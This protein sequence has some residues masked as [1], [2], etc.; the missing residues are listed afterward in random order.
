MTKDNLSDELFWALSLS[1]LQMESLGKCEHQSLLGF[2]RTEEKI[3]NYFKDYLETY[4]IFSQK[5]VK[6]ALYY[7]GNDQ[8]YNQI[9]RGM[10]NASD[11]MTDEEFDEYLER[12]VSVVDTKRLKLARHYGTELMQTGLMGFDISTYVLLCRLCA[13][14]GYIQEQE[15][16]RRVIDIAIVARKYYTNWSDYHKS[17]MLGNQ[18]SEGFIASHHHITYTPNKLLSTYYRIMSTVRKHPLPFQTNNWSA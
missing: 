15:L 18:F 5:D 10:L 17:V 9:F 16:T 7:Y 1:A 8:Q 11:M 6:D 12:Q 4:N 3:V 14:C 13:L 2:D